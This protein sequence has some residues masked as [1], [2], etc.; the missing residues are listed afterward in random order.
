MMC[1]PTYGVSKFGQ[2]RPN[3]SLTVKLS[4]CRVTPRIHSDRHVEANYYS[5]RFAVRWK[6][7]FQQVRKGA[8][9]PKTLKKWPYPRQN[10]SE[11]SPRSFE[12]CF[13]LIQ[14]PNCR[15]SRQNVFDPIGSNSI[16]I[17]QTLF[18]IRYSRIWPN[19][20]EKWWRWF[21]HLGPWRSGRA[22]RGAY[23]TV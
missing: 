21:L 7:T 1:T 9:A 20:I 13:P 2:F 4:L 10:E 22:A 14:G 23:V 18:S 5:V 6:C 17:V 12:G 19:R 15:K 8:F 11:R 16:A 3:E